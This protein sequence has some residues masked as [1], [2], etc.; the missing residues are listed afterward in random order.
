MNDHGPAASYGEVMTGRWNS[1]R[2]TK[3]LLVGGMVA[4]AIYGLGDL[5]SGLLYEG[6]SFRDQAISELTAFG[7]PV[8]PLM[9]TTMFVHSLPLV[10]LAVGLWRVSDRKSVR[11]IG[12]VLVVAAALVLPN[13]TIWPMSSR[14]MEGGFNDTMHQSFSLVWV[15]L[16]MVALV[17]S[18]VAYKGW[19]R[20]YAIGTLVAFVAFGIAASIAIQG[21]DQNVT[22][23]T[24]GFER[25]SA[26]AYF[27]WLAVLAVVAIRRTIGAPQAMTAESKAGMVEPA[28][29][30][31][32]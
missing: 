16:T 25:I 14:W 22:P 19:F 27:V 32:R 31:S 2:V 13:H 4:G 1:R 23:W 20:F 29:M 10:A 24:G 12:A 26:Y 17:L 6:Y 7:S 18:A 11:G 21:I 15:V 3:T 9:L 8:R 30:G 5:V 28:A